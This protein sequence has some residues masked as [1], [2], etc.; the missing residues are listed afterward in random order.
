MS[1]LLAALARLS[2]RTD[3]R[4]KW[5]GLRA[6]GLD[7]RFSFTPV[8]DDAL[9][10]YSAALKPDGSDPD[11][12]VAV[13]ALMKYAVLRNEICAAAGAANGVEEVPTVSD[14]V[15]EAK[16]LDGEN[17]G[18]GTRMLAERLFKALGGAEPTEGNG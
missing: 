16:I 6:K 13:A 1:N 9:K 5:A 3:Y 8:A 14:L 17:S 11:A 18:A 15:A 4:P 2:E 7:L 10:A 12:D